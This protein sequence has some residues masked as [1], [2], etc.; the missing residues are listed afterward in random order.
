MAHVLLGFHNFL[1]PDIKEKEMKIVETDGP[2][3]R[4]KMPVF[5]T[6]SKNSQP[7]NGQ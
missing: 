7:S 2:L 6:W 1:V 3:G 4:D 5:K